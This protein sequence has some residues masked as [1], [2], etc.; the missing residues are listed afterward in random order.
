MK[1]NGTQILIV[2]ILLFILISLYSIL[3]FGQ[4][5]YDFRNPA[6]LSGTDKQIGAVYRFKNVKPGIH[7]NVTITDMTNGL[8]I[9]NIDGG[10]G[11]V[12]ALQPVINVPAGKNGYLEMK[13]DFIDGATGLPSIQ[14]EVPMTPI[15]VDGQMASG[16]PVNEYDMVQMI[17]GYVDFDMLG[18]E[19]SIGFPVGWVT[20]TNTASIDYP[21][22]DTMAKQVMFTV[23]NGSI[24][25]IIARVGAN[26]QTTSSQQRLRS[27][28]FMRFQYPNSYLASPALVSF[29]GNK[30]GDAVKL[31][32][33]L[34]ADN[35]VNKVLLERK[36]GT[37]DFQLLQEWQLNK[38]N[39]FSYT[40]NEPGSEK[41]YYRLKLIYATGKIEYSNILSFRLNGPVKQTIDVYPTVSSGTFTANIYADKTQ[42]SILQWTDMSGRMIQ[43]QQVV[44]QKG[45]NS[46]YL[47]DNSGIKK[48][49]YIISVTMDNKILS[50]R[51]IIQ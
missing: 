45:D 48:G 19:L 25:S 34:A 28:Y 26:N 14:T 32:W 36:P 24:S 33:S 12:E 18:G 7:A 13:I 9:G 47:S 41:V 10:S 37:G 5:D 29:S 23:V 8:T 30:T 35:D 4:P 50:D 20:G 1:T 21:G 11:F 42:S 22:I 44:L 39:D 16:R 49:N 38:E 31:D 3:V 15:D 6:L 2:R 27:I 46:I 40:D 51:V 17:S 43:R